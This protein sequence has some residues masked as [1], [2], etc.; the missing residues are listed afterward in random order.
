MGMGID[1]GSGMGGEGVIIDPDGAPVA[2]TTVGTAV[3][4]KRSLKLTRSSWTTNVSRPP[5]TTTKRVRKPRAPVQPTN[6]GRKFRLDSLRL[7]GQRDGS[8]GAWRCRLGCSSGDVGTHGS[9]RDG[10]S[11]RRDAE[12][13]GS[14]DWFYVRVVP[15]RT[16]SARK[17]TGEQEGELLQE[18]KEIRND[19]VFS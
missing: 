15:S 2:G 1:E 9:L 4:P 10:G 11:V 3:M 7:N 5:A 6:G 19:S 18:G 13:G 8:D 14:C 17:W 16:M 12:R